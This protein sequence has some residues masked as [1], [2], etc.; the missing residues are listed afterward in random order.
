MPRPLLQTLKVAQLESVLALR[1]RCLKQM[2]DRDY[3]GDVLSY[4]RE[5]PPLSAY[6]RLIKLGSLWGCW[7]GGQLIGMAGLNIPQSEL[8][9]LY[10]DPRWRGQGL[11]RQLIQTVERNACR[12]LMTHLQVRA[13]LPAR[14]MYLHLGY[15]SQQDAPVTEHE[16]GGAPHWLMQKNLRRR[17]TRYQRR[18]A[19]LGQQLAVP[20]D[21][22]IRHAL[23]V[24]IEPDQLLDIG[25]DIY[26]RPQRLIA[27]A[28]RAWQDMRGAALA[29]GIELQLVSAYRSVAYQQ[30]IITRKQQRGL[31]PDEIYQVSAAP[32]FSEHHSGRA[33]DLN[34]PDCAVLEESFAATPAY[35]W[36]QQNALSFGF[37][38]SYPRHN[39]H[40]IAWEPWH[41]A[42]EG[43][44]AG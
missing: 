35:A 41:W 30:D 32:G 43:N 13:L 42:W 6:R 40:H 2:Q 19:A 20:A 24:Q 15:R 9:A 36:L 23:P 27:P 16:P 31:S 26:Q 12:Y 14:S 34:T 33:I 37:H 44:Q 7:H 1:L 18:I 10:V 17:W 29:E 22:A 25:C 21:Y 38:E 5:H 28:A 39:L 8:V 4:W 11:A 3:G